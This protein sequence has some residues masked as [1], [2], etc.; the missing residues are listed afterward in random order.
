MALAPNS[1]GRI[2]IG[3]MA[4]W[5]LLAHN[6]PDSP[7][8]AF[9][10]AERN[11]L[12]NWLHMRNHSILAHGFRPVVES[13]WRKTVEWAQAGLLSVLLKETAVLKIREMPP[14]LPDQPPVE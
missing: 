3:L 11:A 9:F 14:Q 4:A 7:A 6:Q 1:R 12:L 8:G 10:R 2:Q 5:E 13:D